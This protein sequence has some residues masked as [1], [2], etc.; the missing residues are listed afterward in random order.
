[1][2]A[3]GGLTWEDRTK[4]GFPAESGYWTCPMEDF[5]ECNSL[6]QF[7]EIIQGK[8]AALACGTAE[9]SI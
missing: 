6:S 8:E 4:K 1:M 9:H 3:P 7:S 2:A 5:E